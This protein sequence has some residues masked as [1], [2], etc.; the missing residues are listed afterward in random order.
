MNILAID[1]GYSHTKC[2]FKDPKSGELIFE[3]HISATAKLP[4]RPDEMDETFC[5]MLE[6]ETYVLGSEALKTEREFIKIIKDFDSMKEVYPIWV[7][8]LMNKYQKDLGIKFD[9]IAIGLSLAYRDRADEL[10]DYLEEKLML[11]NKDMFAVF[12]QGVAAKV[13]ISEY[14]LS[15]DPAKRH[16]VKYNS[17]LLLDGGG[18]T[19][20]IALSSNS[21]TVTS[22]S[23]GLAEFGTV[24]ILNDLGDFIFKQTGVQL[25]REELKVIN[26]TGEWKRRGRVFNLAQQVH[27]FTIKYLSDIV[28]LPDTNTKVSSLIDNVDRVI[29]IGGLA[30][31]IRANREEFDKILESKG[32]PVTFW[33]T[34]ESNS[35]YFNVISY[36]LIAEKM[37]SNN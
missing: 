22:S 1:L 19:L 16:G 12:P 25:T 9:K 24:K 21:M 29:I 37:F 17:I 31:I 30:E 13:T 26:E 35:E 7:S 20:D 18:S 8:F 10:I 23:V 15:L 14:G 28:N 36:F 4:E 11:Q 3:K 5:F 6:N 34:P 33:I 27:D 32:Y 2:A